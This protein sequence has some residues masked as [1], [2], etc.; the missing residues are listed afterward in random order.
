MRP[1]IIRAAPILVLALGSC[2]A[3]G[4]QL[5]AQGTADEPRSLRKPFYEVHR[6]LDSGERRAAVD[7]TEP[8]WVADIEHPGASWLV[9]RLDQVDL[10][11]GGL[12]EITSRLD[13]DAQHLDAASARIW[14]A[15]TAAFRGDAVRLR[16]FAGDGEAAR[17][18]LL[19][20]LAGGSNEA[21][22]SADPCD[23]LVVGLCGG[24]NRVLSNDNRVGRTF[25]SLGTAFRASNGACLTAG[26]L[27]DV[28][29]AGFVPNGSLDV[30]AVHFNAG[31]SFP[32]P[33]V[34]QY[35]VVIDAAGGWADDIAFES[36]GAGRDWAVMTLG[37]N[38]E[39]GL[40][41][42]EAYGPGFWLSLVEP[43]HNASIR[44]T[45]NGFDNSPWGGGTCGGNSASY[46][47]Q[48]ATGP[49]DDADDMG[50]GAIAL[51]YSVDSAPGNEGSP[52]I[53]VASGA[54]IGIATDFDCIDEPFQ[55]DGNRGTSF[56]CPTLKSALINHLG[57]GALHVASS[58]P[59]KGT[60]TNG[61][62]FQPFGTIADA[63]AFLATA[64]HDELVMVL[65]GASASH[66]KLFKAPAGKVL[67]IIA[68]NGAVGIVP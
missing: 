48:T 23:G 17:V 1:Q 27:L 45:G 9:L 42:A 3:A 46:L 62:V 7:A 50:P 6:P 16:L 52:V 31:L 22:D 55:D 35:P 61:N 11:E 28:S 40:L 59:D 26:R 65:M 43:G 24:D 64:S 38:S 12:L 33:V 30:L 36:K 60:S 51:D 14:G 29:S 67:N 4:G 5:H 63:D 34:D 47:Q 41:P 54:A 58:H 68:P 2:L 66:D 20:F 25:P 39:T 57:A 13:G 53:H 49:F 32:S 19:G 44:V 18:R 15:H 10:G 56:N 21:A 8:V 37:A